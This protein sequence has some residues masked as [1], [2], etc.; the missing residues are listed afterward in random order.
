MWVQLAILVVSMVLS[1]VTAAKSQGNA[2]A[3]ATSDDFDFPQATEGTPQ[4]VIF[5]DCWTSDFTVIG[6][7]NYRNSPIRKSGGKK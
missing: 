7:G 3:A 2:A 5:G 4:M 6:L 1:Y